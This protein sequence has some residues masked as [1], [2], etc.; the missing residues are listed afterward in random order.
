MTTSPL[1]SVRNLGVAFP[2]DKK[3]TPVVHNISFDIHAGE[4]LCFLGESGS[5]KSVSAKALLRLLPAHAEVSGQVF[6]DGH[7]LLTASEKHLTHIRGRD[8]GFVFQDPMTSLNPLHTLGTQITEAIPERASLSKKDLLHRL[9]TLLTSVGFAQGADRLDAYPHELSGGQRQRVL[10]AM[11]LAGQPKLLIADEPTTALDVMTQVDLIQHLKALQKKTNMALLLITH[12]LGVAI[13]CADKVFVLKDGQCVEKGNASLLKAPQA[14][15][16][17]NLLASFHHRMSPPPLG[18]QEQLLEVS[19]VG[20][21]VEQR[22]HWFR[23]QRVPLLHDI[24]F[25][26]QKGETLGVLGESGSGKT[27][28]AMALLRMMK[29]T[30]RI[31][32]EGD[33]WLALEGPTLR[34]RRGRLQYIFQ[35]PFGSLNP[36]FLIEDIIKEGLRQHKEITPHEQQRRIRHVMKEVGLKPTL[37]ARYPHELSGGQRQRVAIARAL[38]LKPALLIL[39]EPTSS[40]DLVTQ[41]EVLSLLRHLQEEHTLSYLLITHDLHVMR[42]LAHRLLVLKQGAYLEIANAPDFFR[43]PQTAYGRE[44]LEAS[45]YFDMEQA[46]SPPA[47]VQS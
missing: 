43:K 17:Q 28:L 29:S 32:F 7:P 6:F 12:H 42:A 33:D 16:T 34:Q 22:S 44:L 45:S 31:S 1:L 40:L 27:T 41:T 18:P 23:K 30:G 38:V 36:R 14:P 13:R 4:T 3:T 9:K 39:D 19:N 37:L 11:A 20:V 21:E 10:T 47:P 46:P 2:D 24:T 8:I 5:G 25:S 15:Y 26:M 35:D